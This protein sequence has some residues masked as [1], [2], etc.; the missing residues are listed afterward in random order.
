MCSGP[1]VTLERVSPAPGAVGGQPRLSRT[2]RLIRASIAA[3]PRSRSGL[4]RSCSPSLAG[5]LGRGGQHLVR[6]EPVKPGVQDGGETAGG[7]G[8][9]RRLEEQVHR[10]VRPDFHRQ[11]QRRLALG[12]GLEQVAVRGVALGQG[13]QLLGELQQQLQPVPV[14]HVVEVVGDLLQPGMQ[15]GAACGLCGHGLSPR[16]IGTRTLFPHSVHDPS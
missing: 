16:V 5:E 6:V 14:R 15:G 11:E 2:W 12:H 4:T 9:G 10:V 13:R 8:F 3:M 1:A 7:R